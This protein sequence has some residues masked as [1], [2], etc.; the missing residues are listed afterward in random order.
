MIDARHARTTAQGGVH[1]HLAERAQRAGNHN[2]FSVHAR[3]LPDKQNG[4]TIA[5]R[6]DLAMARQFTVK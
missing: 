6:K 3:T 4:D 5:R 2:G 1:H